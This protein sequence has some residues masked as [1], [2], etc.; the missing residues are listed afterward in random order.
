MAYNYSKLLGR[1]REM[2]KTQGQIAEAIGKNESTLS[3]KLNGKFMFTVGEIDAICREL[4]IGTCDIG[5][6]FFT[7]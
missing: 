6:Y 2:N 5:A 1:M 4:D 7:K 3:S